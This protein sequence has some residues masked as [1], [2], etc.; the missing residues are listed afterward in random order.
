MVGKI[1][2]EAAAKHLTPVCLELGGKSPVYVSE[3]CDLPVTVRRIL[4]G[5][6]SNSGQTCVAPDYVLVHP[7]V[8]KR[9]L[10][11][12]RATLLEWFGA[13][14]Q[15]SADF[16][17]VVSARHLNRLSTALA[18]SL[19][20]PAAGVLFHGGRVDAQDLY[21]APTIVT[22]PSLGSP[23]MTEEIFGPI[24]PVITCRGGVAE[25]IKV[26]N[27]RAKPLALYVFSSSQREID[28]ILAQTSSGGVCINDTVMQVAIA[29][30]PFGGV[31]N[32]GFG[33][34]NGKHTFEL[35]SH[36]K[37]VL[38]RKTWLDSDIRYPPF[39]D[40]KKSLTLRL[41][42]F[43]LPSLPSLS[44]T[45]GVVVSSYLGYQLYLR[46]QNVLPAWQRLNSKL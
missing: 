42:N 2:M 11:E 8:E 7:A 39:T 32:S 19:R 26:V 17:R 27:S 28:T 10:E 40:S 22:N 41:L 21:M 31:G 45:A 38:H 35:F 46:R 13:D 24:L 25:F 20:G 16:G 36:H 37:S 12:M 30:L 5:K 29:D 6:Y 34:Y 15:K 9:V 3:T 44:T 4:S 23:L 18:E 14:P 33:A 1:V 43:Q